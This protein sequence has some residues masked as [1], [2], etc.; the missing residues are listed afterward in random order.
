MSLG[1]SRAAGVGGRGARIVSG[2]AVRTTLTG[3][4]R[5]L[6]ERRPSHAGDERTGHKH[7][8]HHRFLFQ[9][10]FSFAALF[11]QLSSLTNVPFKFASKIPFRSRHCVCRKA[12]L[13]SVSQ[14]CRKVTAE[15]RDLCSSLRGSISIG[16]IRTECRRPH[17]GTIPV[18]RA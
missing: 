17:T 1:A 8:F 14:S 16:P 3:A 5:R 9:L 11:P 7:C 10:L 15:K 18:V 2:N 6:R 13:R 12:D 4:V